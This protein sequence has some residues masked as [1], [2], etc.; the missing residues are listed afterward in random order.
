MIDDGMVDHGPEPLAEAAALPVEREIRR[1]LTTPKTSCTTSSSACGDDAS[2]S[3]QAADQRFVNADEFRP[4]AAYPRDREY[5]K[6]AS[7]GYR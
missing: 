2:L 4:T 6:S 3:H 5:D 1:R 7:S